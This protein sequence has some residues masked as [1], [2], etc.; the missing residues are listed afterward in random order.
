MPSIL[1][2]YGPEVQHVS[3][4]TPLEDILYLIKRDGVVFVR[5][6]VSEADVDKAHDDVKDRLEQDLDWD[7]TFFPS[8]NSQT[9][10]ECI[11]SE[12]HLPA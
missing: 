10:Y 6:L 3:K 9:S 7:G 8:E 2:Q 1:K 4:N 5:N 12:T 11:D